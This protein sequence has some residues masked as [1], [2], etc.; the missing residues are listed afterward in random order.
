MPNKETLLERYNRLRNGAVVKP[1]SNSMAAAPHSTEQY[2]RYREELNK[3]LGI[4]SQYAAQSP[5]NAA[6]V[7][8]TITGGMTANIPRNADLFDRDT[9]RLTTIA[10]AEAI[11]YMQKLGF[12]NDTAY[13]YDPA[14][15][16]LPEMEYLSSLLPGLDEEIHNWQQRDAE[17]ASRNTARINNWQKW[18]DMFNRRGEMTEEN[19]PYFWTYADY[20]LN[21]DP[22]VEYNFDDYNAAWDEMDD[23]TFYSTQDNLRAQ[24]EGIDWERMTDKNAT[25]DDQ[26]Y[27]SQ[28]E[29]LA[30][31]RAIVQG[32]IDRRNELGTLQADIRSNPDYATL[33]VYTPD[34]SGYNIPFA[35]DPETA[36]HRAALSSDL[37]YFI[38]SDASWEDKNTAAGY[39]LSLADEYMAEGYDF[40]TMQEVA[41]YNALISAGRTEDAARYLELLRPELLSRRAKVNQAATESWA[42]DGFWGHAGSFLSARGAALGDIF[43]GIGKTYEAAVGRDH[44]YSPYNDLSN[45]V[46]WTSGAHL[47]EIDDWNVPDWVKTVAKTGYL[48][49]TGAADNFTRLLASGMNPTVAL[50]LAGAQS[51]S[52]SL[53]ETAGRDDMSG[54]AKIVQAIGAA[55]IEVGTEKIGL[56][57]LF[58]KGRAGAIDYIKSVVL[59]ELG[60][61]SLNYISQPVLEAVVAFL[62]DHE[63]EI[64]SGPEFW[65]G[66]LET[67][68]TTLISSLM[69]GAGGAV[70]QTTQHRS[71]GKEY[72][73]AG[74]VSGLI[75]LGKSLGANSKAG[76][77]AAALEAQMAK[78]KGKAALSAVGRL[79]NSISTAIGEENA[80]VVD[81][82]MEEAVEGRL[83]ELGETPEKA[84]AVSPTVRTIAQGKKPGIVKAVVANWSDNAS[85]VVKELTAKPTTAED[86]TRVGQSWQSGM[87]AGISAANEKAITQ[88]EKL[89]SLRA[90]QVSSDVKSAVKSSHRLLKGKAWDTKKT[91]SREVTFTDGTGEISGTINQFKT[92]KDGGLKVEV[93]TAEGA[94]EVD[95]DDLTSAVGS[96]VAAIIEFVKKRGKSL[97][98]EEANSMLR[99]YETVGGDVEQFVNDYDAVYSAA[100]SGLEMPAGVKMDPRAAEIVADAARRQAERDDTNRVK[101]VRTSRA[102]Q[103]TYIGAVNARGE[104]AGTGSEEA[105]ADRMESM[106]ESQR[107]IVEAARAYAKALNVNVVLYDSTEEALREGIMEGEYNPGTNNI[108]LDLNAGSTAESLQ[109]DKQRGTLGYGMASALGHELTHFAETT[110]REAYAELKKAV[111]SV[112]AESG[113]SWVAAVRE[114]INEYASKG[115]RLT[116]AAAEGEVIADGMSM[117]LKD[118]QLLSETSQ[119]NPSLFEKLGQKLKEIIDRIK[120]ALQ[121]LT[122]SRN[123][124]RL[125][126]AA[127]EYSDN[128]VKAYDAALREAGSNVQLVKEQDVESVEAEEDEKF[129]LRGKGYSSAKDTDFHQ[130]GKIYDYDFLTMQN[131]AKVVTIPSLNTMMNG[132]RFERSVIVEN[133]KNNAPGD[134]DEKGHKKI[135]NVY[136]GRTLTI[137]NNSIRHG[138]GGDGKRMLANAQIGSVIGD[139]VENGIP[140]NG[141]NP[142]DGNAVQTYA[143]VTPCITEDGKRM[144]AVTHVDIQKNEVNSVTFTDIVH[145]TNGRIYKNSEPASYATD[146]E[147]R[148]PYHPS[149]YTISIANLLVDVNRTFKSLLSEDVL[150]HLGETR[151]ENG[152]YSNKVLYSIPSRNSTVSLREYMMNLTETPGMNEVE[153]DLLKRYKAHGEKL[154]EAERGIAEQEAIIADEHSTKA[155]VYAAKT[156][157]KI[158]REQSA[159]ET[160]AL[161]SAES[162]GGFARLMRDSY[163]IVQNYLRH[164]SLNAIADASDRLEGEIRELTQQLASIGNELEKA[165]QGAANTIARGMFDQQAL[166]QAAMDVKNTFRVVS[167]SSKEIADRLALAY[168]EMYASSDKTKGMQS[169]VESIRLL[170]EDVLRKSGYRYKS[171][172]LS[173]LRSE[174]G[175]IRLG[176]NEIAELVKNGITL[177]QFK[178]GVAPYL[179]VTE[180]GDDL[181]A[182]ASNYSPAITSMLG[183][184]ESMTPGDLAMHIY[185][186][187][188][189]EKVAQL[190][191]ALEGMTQDQS[192]QYVMAELMSANIPLVEASDSKAYDLLKKELLKNAEGNAKLQM[193]VET[194][195]KK[196]QQASR[197]A[198]GMWSKGARNRADSLTVVDYYR[199]LEEQYRLM[200][201]K[202]Q[203]QRLTAQLKSEAVEKLQ[204]LRSEYRVREERA[205]EYRN[206]RDDVMKLRKAIGKSVKYLNTRRARETD[207]RHI[208]HELTRIVDY[209]LAE[210]TDEKLARLSF[211]SKQAASLNILYKKLKGL[212]NDSTYFWDDEVDE[213]LQYIADLADSYHDL[214]YYENGR[215]K[216]ASLEGYE[217]ERVILTELEDVIENVRRMV[218]AENEIFLEDKDETF[219]EF[220]AATAKALFA[221]KDARLLRGAAGD[222][223]KSVNDLL[224][225]GNMT[226]VYFFERL[227]NDGLMSAFNAV[228]D[229][230][231]KYGHILNEAKKFLMDAMARH[232]YASWVGDGLLTFKTVQGHE[233]T[234]TREQAL[235]AYATAKREASMELKQT[236]HLSKGGFHFRDTK[237]DMGGKGIIR[238]VDEGHQLKD[239]DMSTI[240]NWLTAEQKAYADELVH[241]LTDTM[242]AYGNEASMAM[243]G[244][245]KFRETYYFPFRTWKEQNYQRGDEG[246]GNSEASVVRNASFTHSLTHKAS[247]TLEMSDFTSVIGDHIQAMTT[248]ATM[249][250]PVENIKRLMNH[251]VAADPRQQETLD[252]LL[253]GELTEEDGKKDL[254]IA[255][256]TLRALIGR[257]YG[258]SSEKYVKDFLRDLNGTV[259]VDN[260]AS[261]GLDALIGAFKRGAVAGSLSV[262]VQQPTAIFR[263]MALINPKYFRMNSGTKSD[264]KL[265][266]EMLQYSGAAVVKDAG[267]FDIGLGHSA[268]E[269]VTGQDTMNIFKAWQRLKDQSKTKAGKEAFD[270]FKE[271]LTFLPGK[272]DQLTWQAMWKAVKNEQHEQHPE[273]DT[274]SQEFLELCGKRFDDVVDHTQVYDS[275]LVK[276]NLMRSKSQLHKMATSFMSEP[277]LTLNILIDALWN[278]KAN[279]KKSAKMIA[280]AVV[281]QIAAGALAAAVQA[282]ND[283]D[284]ER[285]AAEKYFDRMMYNIVG[286]L[287][288]LGMVPY[289]SDFVS[290]LEGY[291]VER[292]DMSV[293]S[294]L[295]KYT[296]GFF[297]KLERGD[298]LTAKDWENFAGNWANLTGIPAKN[299]MRDIRRLKNVVTSDWSEASSTNLGYIALDNLPFWADSKYAYYNRMVNAALKGDMKEYNDLMEYMTTSK[300][301][302]ENAIKTGMRGVLKEMVQSGEITPAE[303]TAFMT[304]YAP[305]ASAKDNT[306][307][308]LEWL[309][310]ANQEEN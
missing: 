213:K 147:G 226:P 252:K 1:M 107:G 306:K 289:L 166:K 243:Y 229:G 277:T 173:L 310:E 245:K 98:I 26:L 309:E 175:S 193:R 69:M 111:Q 9:A 189:R 280:A 216:A 120:A 102:G 123:A 196:A 197:E 254:E 94:K 241:F 218:D 222:F 221:R 283:D 194:A 181:S 31:Q 78:K 72:A 129:S 246:S 203:K 259:Q 274:S 244:Y 220:S 51:Y 133:G 6:E 271:W 249:V 141:L 80:R 160:R 113:T 287:K 206:V 257:K 152:A 238:N 301:T 230:Q 168:S 61:E 263:A 276:S 105:L 37:Q 172:I 219:R 106:T 74:N 68:G 81:Q 251:K 157:L 302:T 227:K 162:S 264:G 149:R 303:A 28:T 188:Q 307:K 185:D 223:Q 60:E 22:N 146:V 167:M 128:L 210:F 297:N 272:A 32:E 54:A 73:N 3:A 239:A 304:K 44:P 33:S 86:A 139:V 161:E 65:Q 48:G 204:S 46:S 135:Q 29:T 286:N 64:M 126:D 187:I 95:V 258:E 195:L 100:Y 153:K 266:E 284:D 132:G 8:Q 176:E 58:D 224:W 10:E 142:T 16:I 165:K 212:D 143:M 25:V 217:Q 155:E 215:R 99:T 278:V 275:V 171:E 211:S 121:Q 151:P 52:S 164:G 169:F 75:E 110:S 41:D 55:A 154:A 225:T 150:N 20:L 124:K 247:T 293:L 2:A 24:Y 137:T 174:I 4:T 101:V 15:V 260:R 59:S 290:M 49:T 265:W 36:A 237:E 192:V 159:R 82:I 214:I 170:A 268:A 209:I 256:T 122:P 158:Y 57:A 93:Q 299:I 79:A 21:G 305:Y 248:Y 202:E 84:K 67:G 261:K 131:P 5:E 118:S 87:K 300:I 50:A 281:S 42:T 63:A 288:P 66:L 56:D 136:T 92:D 12:F 90:K 108:Y 11:P 255:T 156:R 19:A 115:V 103:V 250:N 85:Q 190:E 182:L 97:P 201:L 240:R 234:L 269:W 145:S 35:Q 109:N 13:A 127:G 117:I 262:V 233:I 119:K 38:N 62:F 53:T 198:S 273:M 191:G 242:G 70:T 267:K 235:W 285:K 27:E 282:W 205:R 308:P 199:A 138:L 116:R 177:A 47:G 125:M 184:D 236:K 200:E 148:S 183:I 89:G 295:V 7:A 294:T 71:A 34:L 30:G 39:E 43:M 140:I 76:M 23:E 186:L 179:S 232:N 91:T 208:P 77:E 45:Q 88:Y 207:Q 228:R 296:G 83:V 298:T 231:R 144:M 130:D 270:A 17:H 178:K 279:P 114:K 104:V 96:G 112:M 292:A 40:M 163:Q 14:M 291:E 18:S 134:A 253:A 180:S